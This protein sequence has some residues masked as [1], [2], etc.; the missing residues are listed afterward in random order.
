MEG[1]GYEIRKAKSARKLS[2]V[3]FFAMMG[4]GF[5][6]MIGAK[7][8]LVD[9]DADV[10]GYDEIVIGSP[11]WNARLAPAGNSILAKTD[12]SKKQVGFLLYSGSGTGK[13][14]EAKLAKLFP[15][16]KI[17]FLQQPKDHPEEYSKLDSF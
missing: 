17:V 3:L 5:R 10:S 12:L 16:A 11:I 9:Y 14:A 2:K 4:G 15:G 7:D 6:A 1:K 13:K 8:K